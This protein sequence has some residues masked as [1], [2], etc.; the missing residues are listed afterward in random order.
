MQ[1][2][3]YDA[4]ALI[5]AARGNTTMWRIHRLALSEGSAPTVPAP[6]LAQVWRGGSKQAQLAR[7]LNGCHLADFA[8]IDAYEVGQLLGLGKTSDVI[9]A[10][11]LLTAKV[12][13]DIVVTSDPNDL[14]HLA[15]ALGVQV[16]FKVV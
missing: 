14:R 2:L 11:V 8:V 3:T 9:D 13:R 16:K 4:G 1:G 6:A 15:D 5:A 12:R 10:S 7:L